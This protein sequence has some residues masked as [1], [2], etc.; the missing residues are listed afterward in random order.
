MWW[1]ADL[2][3]VREDD[4]LR[5][6]AQRVL[7]LWGGDYGQRSCSKLHR[8]EEYHKPAVLSRKAL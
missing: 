3:F 5:T 2:C 4:S 7:E 6:F 8:T 1:E